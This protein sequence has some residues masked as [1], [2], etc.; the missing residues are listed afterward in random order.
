MCFYLV[1]LKLFRIWLWNLM[2]SLLL[3]FNKYTHIIFLKFSTA[4]QFY[5][6]LNADWLSFVNHLFCLRFLLGLI[7]FSYTASPSYFFYGAIEN[8]SQNSHG[9]MTLLCSMLL[10]NRN[11]YARSSDFAVNVSANQDINILFQGDK[12]FP[13]RIF[14]GCVRVLENLLPYV[15]KK[16]QKL[17]NRTYYWA[18]LKQNSRMKPNLSN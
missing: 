16:N 4:P 2:V 13:R 18:N 7:G 9:G 17:K 1:H 8:K 10:T 14:D 11:A 12:C 15:L 3:A 6:I 5:W